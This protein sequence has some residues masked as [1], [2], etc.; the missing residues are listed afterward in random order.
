M[1]HGKKKFKQMPSGRNSERDQEE[2]KK[3]F[4]EKR[5][6]MSE[7]TFQKEPLW[8]ISKH[9]EGD[10]LLEG[11]ETLRKGG[12]E[13]KGRPRDFAFVLNTRGEESHL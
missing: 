11:G 1:G 4:D 2:K 6:V 5:G 8:E 7:Y 10:S 12:F 3:P 9:E 13:K